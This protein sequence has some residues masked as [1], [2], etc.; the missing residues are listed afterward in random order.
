VISDFSLLSIRVNNFCRVSSDVMDQPRRVRLRTMRRIAS[1]SPPR[2]YGPQ[3]YLSGSRDTVKELPE[4]IGVLKLVY[5]MGY[6]QEEEVAIRGV[7]QCTAW[8]DLHEA[9]RKVVDALVNGNGIQ[10]SGCLLESQ[11]NAPT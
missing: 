1:D 2:C 11:G 4:E 6:E 9:R 5:L 7:S 8:R 3:C 10:L